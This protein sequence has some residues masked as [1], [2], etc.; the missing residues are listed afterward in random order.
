[1]SDDIH[2]DDPESGETYVFNREGVLEALYAND[3]GALQVLALAADEGDEA[4]GHALTVWASLHEAQQQGYE[5]SAIVPSAGD[6]SH[7]APRGNTDESGAYK[8]LD[9]AVDSFFAERRS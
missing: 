7:A 3:E 5:A 8:N 1:M 2:L 4:A 6:T 9:E